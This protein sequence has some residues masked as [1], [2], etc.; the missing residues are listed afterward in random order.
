MTKVSDRKIYPASLLKSSDQEDWEKAYRKTIDPKYAK[1][2]RKWATSIRGTAE[3]GEQKPPLYLVPRERGGPSYKSA[4]LAKNTSD[5]VHYALVSKGFGM[6]DLS[7]FTLG[8]IPGP[9]GGLCLVNYAFSKQV[10]VHHLEGGGKVN[11]SRKTFWQK[12]RKPTREIR[13]LPS[14]KLKVDRRVFEAEEWL[15][16]NFDLWYPEWKKW[17]D[18]VALCSNGNFHWGDESP[19]VKYYHE[20]NYLDFV[21]R[22]KE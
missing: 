19:I 20:G 17:R 2:T 22:K 1:G 13:L 11:L 14:R 5:Q 15:Q 8:P 12:S 3:K 16:D 21:E 10:C 18:I 7:S 6:Q 9:E 4:P